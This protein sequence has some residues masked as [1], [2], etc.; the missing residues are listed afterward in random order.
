LLGSS[1][2]YTATQGYDYSD[3]L[4]NLYKD[5]LVDVVVESHV[6]GNTF[7]P[8]EKT[9]RPMLMKKPFVVFASQDY[10]DYLH[11]MGFRTFNEFWDESY[12]GF[13][14]GDRLTRMYQVIDYIASKE[15]EELE[16][17]Y[18]KME[19]TLEH[20]YSLLTN[21]LFNSTITKIL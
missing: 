13:Q 16:R 19:Y 2:R 18:W 5:I 10:L 6:V 12:D 7:Y 21:K 4:S 11:Q 14:A 15:P 9:I 17:M 1:E 8:T 20:N 3:P